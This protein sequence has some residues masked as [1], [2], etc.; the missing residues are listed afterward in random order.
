MTIHA[1]AA[2]YVEFPYSFVVSDAESL[3]LELI[4]DFTPEQGGGAA[5]AVT[6]SNTNIDQDL[7]V[8]IQISDRTQATAPTSFTI[9]A[10][11]RSDIS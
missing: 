6:R 11:N 9:P 7:T 1:I 10:G 4:G 5:A 3:S 8:F 2:G